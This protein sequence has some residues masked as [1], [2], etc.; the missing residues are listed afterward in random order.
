MG[1]LRALMWDTRR[2]LR[3][4]ERCARTVERNQQAKTRQA[5]Q[6]ARHRQQQAAAFERN[7]QARARQ[8]AQVARQQ[9]QQAQVQARQDALVARQKE[10]EAQVQARREHIDAYKRVIYEV[11]SSYFTDLAGTTYVPRQTGQDAKLP[12]SSVNRMSSDQVGLLFKRAPRR[13]AICYSAGIW[14]GWYECEGKVWFLMERLGHLQNFLTSDTREEAEA[15][16]EVVEWHCAN[17]HLKKPV[18][19]HAARATAPDQTRI[20]RVCGKPG[21]ISNDRCKKCRKVAVTNPP[22]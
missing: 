1:L 14:F 16:W 10:H 9:Q 7:Q 22:A 6:V 3:D 5:A 2:A 19:D 12:F 21:L 15:A 13:S 18:T 11:L 20:C 4:M 17:V 8:A